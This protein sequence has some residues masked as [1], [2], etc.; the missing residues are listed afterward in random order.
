[1]I[2]SQVL[3]HPQT[4]TTSD[5]HLHPASKGRVF[6][7]VWKAHDMKNLLGGKA[8]RKKNDLQDMDGVIL[9]TINNVI[10]VKKY[11]SLNYPADLGY[12]EKLFLSAVA[13]HWFP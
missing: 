13:L 11:Q 4:T 3:S 8:L 7:G 2:Q 9:M 10:I 5:H 1:M 12:R 6:F